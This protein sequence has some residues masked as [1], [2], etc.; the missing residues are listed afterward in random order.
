MSLDSTMEVRALSIQP[1]RRVPTKPPEHFPAQGCVA[2]K[3]CA[4]KLRSRL[5]IS[6]MCSPL[7]LASAHVAITGSYPTPHA[8]R[9]L[10]LCGPRRNCSESLQRCKIR[11]LYYRRSSSTSS[12]SSRC[13]P[14][15]AAAAEA[16]NAPIM[17]D[18]APSIAV[19]AAAL[20]P[21]SAASWAASFASST[22][23]KTASTR[24]LASV[25]ESPVR[26]ATIVAR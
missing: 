4:G 17:R 15:I 3:N 8:W 18:S 14:P 16:M 25:S 21:L 13:R 22:R 12:T 19:V 7:S 6:A 26:D 20:R 9:C 5:W 23:C 11:A 24:A 10:L 1:I 2:A